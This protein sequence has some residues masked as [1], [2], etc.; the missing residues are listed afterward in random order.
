MAVKSVLLVVGSLVAGLSTAQA[1][2]FD[3]AKAAAAVERAIC[4]NAELSALDDVAA[5]YYRAARNTLPGAQACLLADQRNWL[6]QVRNRCPDDQCLKSAYLDRLSDL[7]KV[8]PARRDGE[9]M[10]LPARPFLISIIP[11]TD[12]KPDAGES[13]PARAAPLSASGTLTEVGGAF[14]LTAPGGRS[15]AL[16]NWYMD[17]VVFDQLNAAIL[18]P[19]ARFIV[20]GFAGKNSASGQSYVEP[21]RCI[22]VYQVPQP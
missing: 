21:R 1:A 6:A 13:D 4:T 15:Y 11:P 2:S 9:P 3:C 8:Q 5:R 14:V 18:T 7:D 16:M 10:T 20:R 22:Y 12:R 19:G 17:Q